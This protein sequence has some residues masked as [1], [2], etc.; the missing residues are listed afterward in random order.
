MKNLLSAVFIVSL[1]LIA[2]SKKEAPGFGAEQ[3]IKVH[4]DTAAIDSFSAGATSVDIV[5]Q[6]RM[7]SQKYQDSIKEA[8]KRLKEEQ[9][10]KEELEK[11]N[12]KKGEEEKKKTEAEKKQKTS[13]AQPAAGTKTE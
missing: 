9:K 10:L 6:I 2:C 13:D 3:E 11:E 1:V 5:R 4:Y 8:E 12:K 7:S